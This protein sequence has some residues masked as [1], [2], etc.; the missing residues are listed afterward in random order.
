M[1]GSEHDNDVVL[2]AERRGAVVDGA[3][4]DRDRFVKATEL[5]EGD[6][7]IP[8]R[9]DHVERARGK[10]GRQPFDRSRDPLAGLLVSPE[11]AVH[12]AEVVSADQRIGVVGSDGLRLHTVDL[13]R[14]GQGLVEAFEIDQCFAEIVRGDER[15]GVFGPEP[16][17]P[18]RDDGVEVRHRFLGTPELEEDPGEVFARGQGVVVQRA[19]CVGPETHDRLV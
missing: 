11:T 3:G 4:R 17:I 1:V 16:F 9:D 5:T 18:R 12:H 6:R 14:E 8:P 13:G 10:V 7:E 15:L 19:E 2:V